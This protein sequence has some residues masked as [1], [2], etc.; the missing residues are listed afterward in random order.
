[1]FKFGEFSYRLELR[2]L[3]RKKTEERKKYAEE[4]ET[5][6]KEGQPDDEIELIHRVCERAVDS[7]EDKIAGLQQRF[8][9][10]LAEKYLIHT[11]KYISKDGEWERSDISGEWRW[12]R[13]TTSWV[14][15]RIREEQEYWRV[16]RQNTLALWTGFLGVL[17]ALVSI[18]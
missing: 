7:I 2:S 3:Q 11:P 12:S 6:H 4:M 18:F 10:E 9:T 13:E 17:V 15:A 16:R 14:K 1:M 5:A 8:L